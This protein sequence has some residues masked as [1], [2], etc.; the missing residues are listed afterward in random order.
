VGALV[1]GATVGADVVGATVGA[2]VERMICTLP[3]EMSD[4]VGATTFV[5]VD[6]D[7]E[8]S[9]IAANM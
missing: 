6:T 7:D 4:S 1:V 3:T 9:L 8:A 5:E 2:D